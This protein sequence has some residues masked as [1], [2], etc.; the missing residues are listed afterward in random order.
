MYY[1]KRRLEIMI[2]FKKLFFIFYTCDTHCL[3]ALFRDRLMYRYL[4][5][6]YTKL[7]TEK[8]AITINDKGEKVFHVYA[9]EYK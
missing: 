7:A 2:K 1:E 9:T 8:S 3:K 6:A 5:F 4:F